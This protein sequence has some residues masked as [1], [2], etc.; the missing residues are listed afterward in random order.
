MKDRLFFAK[1][2]GFRLFSSHLL[3][4]RVKRWPSSVNRIEADKA[5]N[6]GNTKS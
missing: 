2:A 3:T 4:K 6:S 5:R 1:L